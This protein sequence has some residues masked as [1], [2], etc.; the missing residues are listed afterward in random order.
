ME[1]ALSAV[2]L[3]YLATAKIFGRF[4]DQTRSNDRLPNVDLKEVDIKAL[5]AFKLW[6]YDLE[7]KVRLRLDFCI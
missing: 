7:R 4:K 5:N 2:N 6:E 1:L 3:M